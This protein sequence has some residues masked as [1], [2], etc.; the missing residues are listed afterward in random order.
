MEVVGA[1]AEVPTQSAERAI[2]RFYDD[3]LASAVKE[4][5]RANAGI[6]SEVGK[7]VVSTLKEARIVA[8]GVI[9]APRRFAR[10]LRDVAQRV[11]RGQ[12]LQPPPLQ[13]AGPVIEGVRWEPEGSPLWSMFAELLA[14][15]LNPSEVHGVHPAFAQLVGQLSP[16]EAQIVAW[17]ASESIYLGRVFYILE[18]E[19]Y[20]HNEVVLVSPLEDLGFDTTGFSGDLSQL[21]APRNVYMY[22]GH[23]TSLGLARTYQYEGHVAYEPPDKRAAFLEAF[24]VALTDFGRL[25]AIACMP[26]SSSPS[27]GRA[28]AEHRV[29]V[30]TLAPLDSPTKK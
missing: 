5:G 3:A 6:V 9:Q 20:T 10:F 2:T 25:F 27:A 4:A 26:P 1:K 24:S 29:T 23:L 11:R 28:V 18:H 14:R 19:S 30:V 15:S 21:H 22:V 13:I 8:T 16:D 17:L 7:L 12:P